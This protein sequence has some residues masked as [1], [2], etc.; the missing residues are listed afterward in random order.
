[1]TT[2]THGLTTGD[3]VFVNQHLANLAANG[4]YSVIVTGTTTFTLTG[5]TGTGVGGATGTVQPLSFNSTFTIPADTVDNLAATSVNVPLEALAD[6]SALLSSWAG[7]YFLYQEYDI[8]IDAGH[9]ATAWSGSTAYNSAAYVAITSSPSATITVYGLATGDEV[10]I[11]F[12]ASGVFSTASTSQAPMALGYISSPSALTKIPNSARLIN[13]AAQGGD[14][15]LKGTLVVGAGTVNNGTASF[16]PI[17]YGD[18]VAV[19]TVSLTGD[20]NMKLRVWRPT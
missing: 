9:A 4:I 10:E 6:R 7:P 18:G 16:Y 13:N 14:A 12:Q 2:G 3:T 15:S 5:T 8:G 11:Q 19:A 20:M 1:V 17:I